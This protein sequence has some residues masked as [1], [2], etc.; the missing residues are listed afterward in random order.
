MSLARSRAQLE[1][2]HLRLLAQAEESESTVESGARSAADWMAIETRQIRRDARSDLKLAIKLEGHAY[3]STALGQG[4]VNVAQSRAIVAA[5]E[6]LPRSGEFAVTEEQCVA[7]EAHLVE[8]AAHHDAKELRV[9]GR[10]VFEVIAP[11]L[12][13]TFEGRA[14]EQEEAQALRR[15]TFTMR[16]DD[17]GT[18]HGRFRIPARHGQMLTKLILALC[19]PSRSTAAVDTAGESGRDPD[20]PTPVRHGIVFTQLLE[21]SPPPRCRS[22]VAAPRPSW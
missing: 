8:L 13:E 6:R 22:P 19:S 14:L 4:R 5:L 17:E 10:H 3:L 9:Q 21:G 7:A 1:A 16:D 18:C 15:T 2:L 20:L 11:E 12:A